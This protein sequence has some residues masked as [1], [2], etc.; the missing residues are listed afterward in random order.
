M[1]LQDS[2]LSLRRRCGVFLKFGL[3]LPRYYSKA[4]H[5]LLRDLDPHISWKDHLLPTTYKHVLDLELASLR[6]Q[7]IVTR[8]LRH[9]ASQERD[10][11]FPG[12]P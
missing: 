7:L 2:S 8:S 3:R 6:T 1:P 10:T 9:R 12:S 11:S 5:L 4:L